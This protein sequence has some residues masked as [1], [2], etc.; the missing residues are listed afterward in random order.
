MD[1]FKILTEEEFQ[2]LPPKKRRDYLK[3]KKEHD[4]NKMVENNMNP[5]TDEDPISSVESVIAETPITYSSKT[6]EKKSNAGRKKIEDSQK[7]QQI[8]LT[9]EAESKSRLESVDERNYKKL[10]ARY[11]DKNIDEIVNAIKQL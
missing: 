2:A 10:L 7:K 11:I 1:D 9:I 8:M 6:S 3:Q 5:D 4:N